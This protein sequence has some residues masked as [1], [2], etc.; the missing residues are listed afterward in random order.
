MNAYALGPNSQTGAYQ[1]HV[2]RCLGFDKSADDSHVMQSSGYDKFDVSR[3][4]HEIPVALPHEA[5]HDELT[6]THQVLEDLESLVDRD[7]LPPTYPTH[8]VVVVPLAFGGAPFAK[9]DGLLAFWIENLISGSRTL[10]CVLRKSSLCQCGC[11]GYCTLFPVLNVQ[12]WSI[13]VMGREISQ[14]LATT[15]PAGTALTAVR[16]AVVRW[17]PKQLSSTSKELDGIRD[18]NVNPIMDTQC[19]PVPDVLLQSQHDAR[20]EELHP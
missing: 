14:L 1:R 17:Q 8:P 10:A 7:A 12:R 2:D 15:D 11:R 3:S 18:N 20:P 13:G 9:R 19:A 6:G 16:A 4:V 5:L